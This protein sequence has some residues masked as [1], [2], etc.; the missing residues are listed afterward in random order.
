MATNEVF[1]WYFR[2]LKRK[3]ARI[4]L[5]KFRILCPAYG[6]RLDVMFVQLFPELETKKGIDFSAGCHNFLTNL[7]SCTLLL[8]VSCINNF[9]SPKVVPIFHNINL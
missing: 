6:A 5:R 8:P 9:S 4:L 7:Q 2:F 3:V 1:T